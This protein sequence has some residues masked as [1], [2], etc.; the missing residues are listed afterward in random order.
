MY[1]VF[2]LLSAVMMLLFKLCIYIY[3]MLQFSLIYVVF[4]STLLNIY[5]IYLKKYIY[6]HA[7]VYIKSSKIPETDITVRPDNYYCNLSNVIYLIKCKKCESVNYIGETST[8]LRLNM[9]N[10]KKA[11]DPTTKE[12]D[13]STSRSTQSLTLNALY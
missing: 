11:S 10:H 4:E 7:C 5:N 13:I 6:I 12:P 9:N 1:M 3:T 8:I 2:V